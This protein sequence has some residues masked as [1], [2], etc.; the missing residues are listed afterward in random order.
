MEMEKQAEEDQPERP[1][2]ASERKIE[3]V[4]ATVDP[5]RENWNGFRIIDM[6]RV[7]GILLE[8]LSC[9]RCRG[10]AKI[11]E[12][13]TMGF[14]SQFRL[15]C[16]NCGFL[17]VFR[18]SDEVRKMSPE[19]PMETEVNRRMIYASQILGIRHA[20]LSKLSA[21][22]DMPQ[23]FSNKTYDKRVKVIHKQVQEKAEQCMLQAI[24]KEVELQNSRELCASGD[25]TWQKKGF[26]SKNGVVSLI[27]ALSGEVLDVETMTVVCYGHSKYKGPKSGDEFDEWYES[28]MADCTIN[29][30]GSSGMMEV[31]GMNRIFQRSEARAGVK[32]TKYIGDGDSKTFS[33]LSK[34]KPYGDV[35]IS[36]VRFVFISFQILWLYFNAYI[37]LLLF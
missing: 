15:T 11:E 33:N 18:N 35:P 24:E 25:G 16:Q 36:K 26:S 27:G 12:V 2:S 9:R 34:S 8:H 3:D 17:K 31:T 7:F 28:H 6:D 23:I 37:Y 20:G 30:Q 13:R 32:Y 22:L 21:L 19:E 4:D 5:S 10:K 14:S 29:H 1:S